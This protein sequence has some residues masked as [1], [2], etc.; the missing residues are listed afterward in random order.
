M[1]ALTSS[2]DD[3][4]STIVDMGFVT[5]KVWAQRQL[6]DLFDGVEIADKRIL[7][8]GGGSGIYS[9][10]A[11]CAGAREV[12]CLEPEAAGSM[13]GVTST[14][15]K[16]RAQLPDANVTLDPRT[17]QEY[18]TD[19]EKFDIIFSHAS[20]NHLDEDACVTLLYKNESW[21]SYKT[22]LT[23]IGGLG[24]E[25]AK[26]IVVDCSRHNFFD[27]IGLKNPFC[28]TI[29][30]F[31]HQNP[32]VWARLLEEAGFENPQIRWEPLYRFGTIG[33]FLLGNAAAAYFLKS[34]FRL[35]MEKA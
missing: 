33:K 8:I 14:F 22:I 21:N 29:E 16:I 6:E 23:A 17:I 3:Y 19:G 20:I 1:A 24:N 27:T 2:V 15:E 11:A 35:E 9:F 7:D 34:T 25:G 28:P 10:Y 13:S 5:S 31:K 18:P 30:W 12:I 26:I 32:D 4:F